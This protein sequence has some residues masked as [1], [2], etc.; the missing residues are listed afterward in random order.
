MPTNKNRELLLNSVIE[1]FRTTE[2]PD[3]TADEVFEKF[4]AVQIL[5]PKD[6]TPE[7]LSSG[8]V[9]GPRDGGID[10][11]YIFLNGMLLDLD[12]PELDSASDAF[13]L[14]GKFPSLEIIMFQ[15]KNSSGFQE[16]A[17]EHLLS[18]LPL[19][20]DVQ[21]TESVL[22][23]QF[24]GEVVERTGLFRKA[25]VVLAAKHPVV[26]FRI[27]YAAR[28]SEE[29]VTQIIEA[30]KQQ[31][32]ELVVSML[33]H[34]ATVKVEHLGIEGLYRLEGEEFGYS[35]TLRFREMMREES[36]FIGIAA[37]DEYLKFVRTED[38]NL[39]EDIFDSNVRDFE[40]VN[41]VNRSIAETLSDDDGIEFWWLNN[42]IT[43][44]GDKV[45]SPQ[46]TLTISRP[47]VVN[48]LQTSHV[49]H[50]AERDGR[51]ADGRRENGIVVRV[52]ETTD[53][54][55]RGRIIA[56]TNRQTS[57]PTPALFATQ[58]LQIEIERYLR[59]SDW[60]YE[61]RKNRYKNQGIA[62]K[63]RITM[64][65]LAQAMITLLLGR[66]D[67][68]RARPSTVISTESGYRSVFPEYL[69][70]EAYHIAIELMKNIEGFLRSPDAKSLMNEFTNARFFVASG[71]VV[72]KLKVRDKNNLRF[73][74]NLPALRGSPDMQLLSDALKLLRRQADTF[75]EEHPNMARDAIFK[76]ANFRDLYL[77]AVIALAASR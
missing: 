61:R 10:G 4:A 57:V 68:A 26:T 30:K 19:L 56:G 17:W 15:A 48:G 13:R 55:V 59:Q 1:E 11:F 49:M 37:L 5:K 29:N 62:A 47:L 70:Y 31:V 76:N 32:E 51:F 40:G 22:G 46:S 66:P 39:R 45:D 71:Y 3:E 69:D 77:D 72:L 74:Q 18:S 33:T 44:L 52:I 9:D 41:Y 38:G 2:Y 58:E 6:I 67:E 36:S 54:S 73:S 24:N 75:E 23:Q 21:A 14:T 28:A 64:N 12:S 35:G 53:E 16:S 42:G 50:N 63:K 34:G 20:L 65:Y 60:F 8:I 43:V 7:E 25:L 27:V